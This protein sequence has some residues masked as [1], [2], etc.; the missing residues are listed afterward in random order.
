MVPHRARVLRHASVQ[1]F[2]SAIGERVPPGA[3]PGGAPAEVV[4][5]CDEL[6]NPPPAD[7]DAGLGGFFWP[8]FPEKWAC[9]NVTSNNAI[10]CTPWGPPVPPAI[11]YRASDPEGDAWLEVA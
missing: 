1:P 11:D 5:C 7:P 8:E 2:D 4:A 3:N 9:C 10:A 6:L